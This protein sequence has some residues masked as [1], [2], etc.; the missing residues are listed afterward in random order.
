MAAEPVIECSL[1][2][3]VGE[4][5]VGVEGFGTV[6][7]VDTSIRHTTAQS[8]HS[9]L[10]MMAMLVTHLY[11]HQ[12]HERSPSGNDLGRMKQYP[13]SE[14]ISMKHSVI[15]RVLTHPIAR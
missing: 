3:G 2:L 13:A 6:D 9:V 15:S 1:T 11:G 14:F 10:L 4:P 12:I 8:Q 7:Q 5:V